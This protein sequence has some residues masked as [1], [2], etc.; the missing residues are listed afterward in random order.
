MN[1]I[2]RIII[3]IFAVL[4]VFGAYGCSKEDEISSLGAGNDNGWVG[5]AVMVGS[6]KTLFDLEVV[7][8]NNNISKFKV[9][10]DKKTVGEALTELHLIVAENHGHGTHIMKVNG[11]EAKESEQEYWEFYID[12]EV[13]SQNVFATEIEKYKIY[14]FKF[15]K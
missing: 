9:A 12:G 13:S 2:K 11:I 14:G 1:T 6:G 8:G 7:D 15:K 5:E 10:T 4:T 3:C